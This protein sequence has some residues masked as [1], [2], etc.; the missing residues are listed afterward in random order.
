MLLL[1]QWNGAG[2]NLIRD[3]AAGAMSASELVD[4]HFCRV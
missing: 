3:L 2:W 4:N 1:D